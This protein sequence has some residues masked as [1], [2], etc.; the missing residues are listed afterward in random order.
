MRSTLLRTC[1]SVLAAVAIIATAT[2]L[3]SYCSTAVADEP[4]IIV[5]T[6]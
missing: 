4:M 6:P 2:A 1:S 3:V 5:C